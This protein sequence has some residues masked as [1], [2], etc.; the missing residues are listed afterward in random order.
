MRVR[1]LGSA[2]G[3]G[4]P[5]WNCACPVCRD[6]RRDGR[7]R[8]QDT[9]AVTGDGTAWY[10]LNAG[11]DIRTQVLRTPELAPG[12][13]LRETPVRGVLLTT[14]ELDHTLGLL[15]LREAVRIS[16]YATATVT[17]ALSTAFPLRPMLGAYTDLDWQDLTAGLVLDGGLLV[18]RLTVGTKRP[19]YAGDTPGED[20]VSALRLTD[21]RSGSS[22]VYATC[23]PAWTPA[24]G[25]FVT[26]ADEVLLDGT[27]T[28]DDELTRTTGRPG[29]AQA[30]G[31]LP[32]AASH[33]MTTGYPG[34]RFRYGHL[35]N[36]NPS[37]GA[38]IAADGLELLTDH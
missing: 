19:R 17:H 21:T 12:P 4:A 29:S 20:W 1:V 33:P 32:M 34:T 18:H 26:G 14:A 7:D 22:F 37:L 28:T 23:L 13:G 24:F 27:F 31:H 36:T 16:V 10:L 15:S 38:D 25:T 11:P 3:G 8:T 5:Q 30:M 6:A 2:A 35:N 9:V